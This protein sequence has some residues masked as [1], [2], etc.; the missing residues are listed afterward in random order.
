MELSGSNDKILKAIHFTCDMFNNSNLNTEKPSRPLYV[1]FAVS[2]KHNGAD[3]I[4]DDTDSQKLVWENNE[5]RNVLILETTAY[6]LHNL[7]MRFV[8]VPTNRI[9]VGGY[10]IDHILSY[11]LE[12]SGD[13]I[14][15]I[16]TDENDKPVSVA[17]NSSGQ[18]SSPN[19]N[20]NPPKIKV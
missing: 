15:F 4:V 1:D 2:S 14:T 16:G 6:P 18:A 9:K 11:K 12:K 13:E 3:W 8:S 19:Q 10:H 17:I 7:R 20:F 5:L